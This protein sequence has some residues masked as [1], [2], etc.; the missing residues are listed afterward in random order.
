MAPRCMGRTDLSYLAPQPHAAPSLHTVWPT[1]P[2]SPYCRPGLWPLQR[3][4]DPQQRR[5]CG[6]VPK[7][8]R[9]PWP[10]AHHP[11]HAQL[12][13]SAPEP[14]GAR[15]GPVESHAHPFAAD[16]VGA[17]AGRAPPLG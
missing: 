8:S 14:H 11:S 10:A 9:C 12:P 7:Q 1:L 3:L 2:A 17:A 4:S 13:I 16:H 15:P 6:C 5:C